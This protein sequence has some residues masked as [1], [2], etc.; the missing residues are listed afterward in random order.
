M[1]KPW[2]SRPQLVSRGISAQGSSHGPG[3]SV[4]LGGGVCVG[5]R[6]LVPSVAVFLLG[7][8]RAAL[9][10]CSRSR[11]CRHRPSLQRPL[12]LPPTDRL[13][14]PH[15]CRRPGAD[16]AS[17]SPAALNPLDRTARRRGVRTAGPSPAPSPPPP[18]IR[19]GARPCPAV[20]LERLGDREVPRPLQHRRQQAAPWP[21][22]WC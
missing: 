11:R 2:V 19:N 20:H 15:T 9:R 13:S 14:G 16:R 6:Q 10:T 21:R 17:P 8:C 1:K 3:L 4:P 5:W 22:S 7:G 12:G 18:A